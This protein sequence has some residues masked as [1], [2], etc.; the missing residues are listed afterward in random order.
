[1]SQL[2]FGSQ[3]GALGSFLSVM[4]AI[5]APVDT[6]MVTELPP[7]TW[8][9]GATAATA[10]TGVSML[11]RSTRFAFSPYP[12]SWEVASAARRPLTRGTVISP[13][14]VGVTLVPFPASTD[15]RTIATMSTAAATPP[16]IAA[17]RHSGTTFS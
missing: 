4:K 3:F 14:V 13:G 6:Y 17:R 10:P 16:G 12:S 9:P 11:G 2:Q 5:H 7:C 15:T 1:M 8:P